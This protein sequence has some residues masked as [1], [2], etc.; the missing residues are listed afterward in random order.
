MKEGKKKITRWQ[1]IRLLRKHGLLADKHNVA[2][3]QNKVA[4]V[5][6]Y[7]MS[8]ITMLYL[9]FLAVMLSLI[10]NSSTRY[11]AC[12]IMF[13]ILPFILVIDFLFRFMIQQTPSQRIKPYILLPLGKY[14]CID[15]FLFNSA[16]SLGNLIWMALFVPYAIMSVLFVEGFFNALGFLL[17]LYL[18]IVANSLWY[19][20]ARTLINKSIFWWFLPIAVYALIFSPWY[21][22]PDADFVKLCETYSV[23]GNGSAHW[24]I[25][26]FGGILLLIC[27]IWA[28]NRRLQ[29]DSVY[30][31]LSKNEKTEIKHVTQLGLFDRYGEV[32]EYLKLEIKS[33]MRNK[34]I[35][36]TFIMAN[37]LIIV[38][39]LLISF[40]D[41]YEGGMTKFLAVYNFAIFGAMILIRA[42]CYE[43]NYID[44]LM[45]HKEN[46][47]SLLKAKYFLYTF[48]LLL[49]LLLMIP[50][51][52]MGKCTLLMLISIMFL[53]GGP[54]HACFLY[55]AIINKQT[56]PLNTKFIGK[57]TTENNFIQVVVELAAFLLPLILLNIL[58]V[59]LGETLG[60]LVLLCM[61]LC[62]IVTY[63]IW[64]RDIYKRMMKR[65]Y[66]NL[67]SFHATR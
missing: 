47:I 57:G 7:V 19:M 21:I 58:P 31:E 2:I 34:N 1:M 62:F 46:I 10:A 41:I 28:I 65:R 66:E 13:G 16:T 37:V 18:I 67:E 4:K 55:L 14:A 11:T 15:C 60:A 54:I 5:F 32:G 63:P 61:G 23:I 42:M 39:S 30:A 17:A 12:E 52:V 45:V 35:R 29:Y 22:G 50:T 27:L 26:V 33:I 49:P 25:I 8:A 44:C 36:K 59:L 6:G 3:E 48:L 40:T 53:V 38:F 56:I 20:I 24:S 51:V 9:M 43:G 64:I